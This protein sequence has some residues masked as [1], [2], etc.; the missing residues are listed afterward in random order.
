MCNKEDVGN[1]WERQYLRKT[2]EMN[3]QGWSGLADRLVSWW[4]G[5]PQRT[6][7]VAYVFSSYTKGPVALTW[8]EQLEEEEKS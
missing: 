2:C 8:G 4:T 5:K 7:E 1:G 6:V 3:R